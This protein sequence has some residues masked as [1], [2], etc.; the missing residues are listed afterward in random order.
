MKS[1]D[2]PYFI[3]CYNPDNRAG[4]KRPPYFGFDALMA[5]DKA[6]LNGFW[7]QDDSAEDLDDRPGS[8]C[9]SRTHRLPGSCAGR[10]RRWRRFG[11][12]RRVAELSPG[13]HR[14]IG[15]SFN[16]PVKFGTDVFGY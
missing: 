1:D 7:R 12:W 16:H 9:C 13:S 6:N 15:G 10:K 3:A 4:R 8:T 5:R 11:T 2:L 14:R